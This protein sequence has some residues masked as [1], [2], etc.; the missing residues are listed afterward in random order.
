MYYILK[1]IMSQLRT[2]W[3]DRG[4]IGDF[5]VNIPLRNYLFDVLRLHSCVNYVL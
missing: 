1:T 4:Y 2:K 5:Y 3:S